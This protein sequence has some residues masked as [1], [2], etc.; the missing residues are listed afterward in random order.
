MIISAREWV[1]ILRFSFF[2]SCMASS[3]VLGRPLF[4]LKNVLNSYV[5]FCRRQK[6]RSLLARAC[7][8]DSEVAATS[9]A[10]KSVAFSHFLT[11][12]SAGTV[13]TEGGKAARNASS[14]SLPLFL[15]QVSESTAGADVGV[16]GI[17]PSSSTSA[18]F[19]VGA[20]VD[21]DGIARFDVR[22]SVD[23]DGIVPS[24]T[25]AR[26]DVGAAVDVDGIAPSSTTTALL[27]GG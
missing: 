11:A 20:D 21:V 24:S 15:T 16:D 23:V 18:R 8:S 4:T 13:R 6:T 17:A 12:M 3:L 5:S 26:F 1:M 27:L 22:D 14:T 7:C 25:I 2:I 9:I 10:V 19:D